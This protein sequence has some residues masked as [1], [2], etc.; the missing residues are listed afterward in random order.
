MA[1]IVEDGTGLDNSESYASVSHADTHQTDRGNTLWFTL[2]TNEKEQ[3]LRRATDYMTQTYRNRWAGT[4][5]TT[6]QSLDWPRYGIIIDNITSIDS[7]IVPKDIRHSCIE[8]AFK[9][10]GGDLI[11]DIK[12][13]AIRKKVGDIEVE[14]D[15]L[16]SQRITYLDIDSILAPY[17]NGSSSGINMRLVRA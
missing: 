5:V 10:A 1:L 6:T 14:Y 9:A 13:N 3:A 7:N 2:S 17:L 15:R 4:R 11:P 8:L 12:Q 16:S